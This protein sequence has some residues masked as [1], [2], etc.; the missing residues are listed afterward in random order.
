MDDNATGGTGLAWIAPAE[1][2]I[3]SFATAGFQVLSHTCYA[4]EPLYAPL[5][6]VPTCFPSSPVSKGFPSLFE[7]LRNMPPT[8]MVRLRCGSRA[9]DVAASLLSI[10]TTVSCPQ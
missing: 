4:V 3:Q 2:L 10:D 1:S 5:T 9:V 6:L 7:A 8:P